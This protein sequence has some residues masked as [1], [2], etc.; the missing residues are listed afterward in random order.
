MIKEDIQCWPLAFMCTCVYMHTHI[1][2]HKTPPR[3][4]RQDWVHSC[5]LCCALENVFI[6]GFLDVS[7]RRNENAPF[8]RLQEIE[9]MQR[10]FSPGSVCWLISDSEGKGVWLTDTSLLLP[11]AQG[12]RFLS[13]PNS[14]GHIP[15]T[16]TDQDTRGDSVSAPRLP[17]SAVHTWFTHSHCLLVLGLDLGPQRSL[18]SEGKCLGSPAFEGSQISFSKVRYALVL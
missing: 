6:E 16:L 11:Q 10:A 14:I 1:H 12:P 7:M 15:S 5:S 18:L 4:N 3:M 2:T 17:A 8:L 13:A 9:G